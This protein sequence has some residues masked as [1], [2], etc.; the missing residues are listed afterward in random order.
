MV[1]LEDF[2]RHLNIDVN[3][4]DEDTLLSA[5]LESSQE[6]IESELGYKILEFNNIDSEF[7]REDGIPKS[8]D[9]AIYILGA[10]MYNNGRENEIIGSK[11]VE[12]PFG[13]K[14]IVS[15]YKV[16]FMGGITNET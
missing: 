3:Y 16:D 11:V 4:Q 9:L 8:I 1:L 6:I 10:T 7:Y 13:V 5:L 2:K 14:R 15:P 12:M